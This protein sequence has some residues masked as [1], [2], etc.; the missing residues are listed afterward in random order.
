MKRVTLTA[1]A[2][3]VPSLSLAD[4]L[5]IEETKDLM[6]ACKDVD[7][8]QRSNKTTEDMLSTGADSLKCVCYL[9][10]FL[11]GYM[12]TRLAVGAPRAICPRKGVSG[13]QL[14][15]VYVRWASQHPELWHLPSWRTVN[16][17]LR[18]AF[19]CE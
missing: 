9:Y 7:R 19:P 11:G 1:L 6:E 3:L 5:R 2:I 18:D 15:A 13:E 10:G 8:F 14:A 16:M 4:P 17:A 12:E